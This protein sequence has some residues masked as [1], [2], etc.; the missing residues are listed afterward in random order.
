MTFLTSSTDFPTL[1]KPGNTEKRIKAKVKPKKIEGNSHSSG[2][3]RKNSY[4]SSCS[5][6]VTL[7]F[8]G[9]ILLLLLFSY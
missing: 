8:Y 7:L 9:L 4:V 3:N 1:N 5:V 6:S 2:F